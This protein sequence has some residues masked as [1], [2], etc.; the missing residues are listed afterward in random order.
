METAKNTTL[1]PKAII[2]QKYG[3]KACYVIEEVQEPPQHGCPGL[4][5]PQKGPSLFRCSLH[6]PDFSVV[7]SPCKK[8]K[9]AQQSAALL[10]LQKLGIDSQSDSPP[11]PLDELVSRLSYMFSDE[12]LSSLHPMSGHLKAVLRREGERCGLL[13][14][15]AVISYDAKIGNSCKSIDARV[16]SKPLLSIPI[17]KAVVARLPDLVFN[18]E[19]LWIK[20]NKPYASDVI[21]SLDN[22]QSDINN[23]A[24]TEAVFIPP[25]LDKDVVSLSMKMCSEAYYL[26]LIAQEL[27]VVDASKVLISRTIGKSSSE[28]RLYFSAQETYNLFPDPEF[29]NTKKVSSFDSSFNVRASYLLGQHVYGNA[30]LA[31]V[32]YTWRGAELFCEDVSVRSYFRM[33]ASK[34][35][36][37]LFKLSRDAMIVADLPVLFT[38]KTNWRGSLP[39]DLLC[40]FCRQHRLSEPVLNV[41]C[42]SVKSNQ[43]SPESRNKLAAGDTNTGALSE[44]GV[45][46]NGQTSLGI[47]T[48]R[49]NINIFSKNQDLILECFPEESFKKQGDAVQNA[50]LKALLWFN[51]Y[52]R[53][54]S[55]YTEKLPLS[56]DSHEL[57]C[58]AP[59]FFKEFYFCQLMHD[60]QQPRDA[61]GGRK[62][63]RDLVD[64]QNG[65]VNEVNEHL[66][67]EGTLSGSSPSIGSLVSISYTVYLVSEGTEIR[68]VID[69]SD[70]FEF[71]IGTGAVI[72]CVEAAVLQMKVGHSMCFCMDLPP[73]ELIL[74]STV[75]YEK[76]LSFLSSSPCYLECTTSILRVTEPL[77]DRMEQALFSPPLS[78]QRLEFAMQCIKEISATNLIDFG[79]GSGSLLESLLESLVDTPSSLKKIVGV[80]LSH[81][82]LVRAAK[83]INSKLEK[84]KAAMPTSRIESAV[85][86]DGSITVFDSRLYGYDVGACLEVIEHMEEDE[87]CIFGNVALGLYQPKVLI[88]ST[89]NYEYNVIMQKSNIAATLDED[90]DDKGETRSIK[91][92]NHDHK[93]EWTRQQFNQWA[94]DLALK[95]NYSV[96]FG[97]VG[98]DGSEPGFASQIAIF[99]RDDVKGS[100]LTTE[101]V[102]R[103]NT[104]WEW[105]AANNS[106]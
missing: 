11:D 72:S 6:L 24:V 101:F 43:E 81:K 54:P 95:H 75:D 89:P 17:V 63:N 102:Q 23:E 14:L 82:G 10:A 29:D 3:T 30:I 26:D 65:L 66:S 27:G 88:V 103:Y 12:F 40:A 48:F 58:N 62:R 32:G 59:S 56:G 41:V 52:C 78:K 33:L 99:R 83:V 90:P 79:C 97:G 31:S 34:T 76:V 84:L 4:A 7:S 1:T 51:M 80:D 45:P 98:G 18:E 55:L 39:R 49:C 42:N 25:S 94:T 77:E 91:F 64:S 22:G 70:E 73:K 16:E 106:S 38:T 8:K 37:G 36:D 105:N 15:S 86:Y 35:P 61:I 13:P 71:E 67:T 92:R 28:T 69:K 104:I 93:F 9:D 85:L 21:P 96:E 20:R 100:R 2:H 19:E 68:V 53:Q 5:F 74:A 46:T 87:A 47:E 44:N 57:K 60:A 50:S